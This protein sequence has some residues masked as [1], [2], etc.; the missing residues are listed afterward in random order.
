M[1]TKSAEEK[2]YSIL[3]HNQKWS[4]QRQWEM[5]GPP[6]TMVKRMVCYVIWGRKQEDTTRPLK[7]MVIV[8]YIDNGDGGVS[9][10]LFASE[11]AIWKSLAG[12][13]APASWEATEAVL[14]WLT[15]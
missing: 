15:Q 7:G 12:Q 3:H 4:V 8:Q 13:A 6:H 14:D 2:I 5:A 11:D 10:C 1:N 9:V